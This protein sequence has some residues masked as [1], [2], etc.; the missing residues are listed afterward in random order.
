[1]IYIVQGLWATVCES[2]SI[3][4]GVIQ[5]KKNDFI[6]IHVVGDDLISKPLSLSL[7]HTLSAISDKSG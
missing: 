5:H 7:T 4:V 1:M 6:L 3:F 2:I